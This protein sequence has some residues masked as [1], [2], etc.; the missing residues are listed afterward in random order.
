MRVIPAALLAIALVAGPAAA[1]EPLSARVGE[2]YEIFA[3]GLVPGAMMDG[4]YFDAVTEGIE[5]HWVFASALIPD[6]EDLAALDDRIVDICTADGPGTTR[7]AMSGPFAFTASR[8][9]PSASITITFVYAGGT[10]F[11]QQVD[12]TGFLTYLGLIDKENMR[13]SAI[14]ALGSST[15]PVMIF[16]P[17]SDILVLARTEGATEVYAKCPAENGNT[18]DSAVLAT[19]IGAAFDEQYRKAKNPAVRETFITCVVDALAPLPASD[20]Q[21]LLDTNFKP[22]PAELERIGDAYPA[23]RDGTLACGEAVT[24]VLG[25]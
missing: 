20:L 9:G 1:Q 25:R 12:T 24:A 17:D 16:R 7:I 18:I 5:G 14:T 10:M 13:Q 2:A 3:Q 4:R 19:A 11:S 23:V 15:A 21:V 8:G 6:K 22:E